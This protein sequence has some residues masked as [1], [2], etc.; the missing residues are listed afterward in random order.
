MIAPLRQAVRLPLPRSR[1]PERRC[2]TAKLDHSCSEHTG[3]SG[4][5]EVTVRSH[6]LE[7]AVMILVNTGQAAVLVGVFLRSE[8]GRRRSAAPRD[9]SVPGC[10]GEPPG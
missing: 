2:A 3:I 10:L 4:L 5:M 6:R 8:A 9:D 1:Q 7:G